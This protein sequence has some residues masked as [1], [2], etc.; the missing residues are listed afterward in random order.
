MRTL[1]LSFLLLPAAALAQD[2]TVTPGNMLAAP[3][4]EWLGDT[5]HLVLMGTLS[6]R[7]VDIQY[8][9]I[10]AASGIDSFEGKREY[11]PG[12][13]GS[14]RYGDFEV[15][16]S[17]II[18]GV[19]KSF[20]IEIENFD[21][22][23]ATL[24]TTFTLGAENFPQGAAAFVEIAAEWEAGGISVNDEIGAWTGTLTLVT[25]TGTPDAEGL[26][27]DGAIGGFLVAQNGSDSLVASFT[28]S[29]VEYEKD[30]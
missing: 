13:G 18:D 1:I 29:V 5:P 19:E 30:E 2:A 15:A 21:F 16:L 20:E 26:V 25:D 27:P 8:T 11:L 9:D 28:V 6:G 17:A 10:A 14:W 3:P 12:D 7:P 22:T 4:G 23:E 24:P